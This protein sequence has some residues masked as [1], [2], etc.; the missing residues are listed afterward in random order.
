MILY[1]A[2]LSPYVRKVLFVLNYKKMEFEHKFVLP[3]T[4]TDEYLRISPLGKIPALVDGDLNLPDSSVICHY[5]DEHFPALPIRPSSDDDKAR[6]HWIEEYADTVVAEA[7]SRIFFQRI[8][9][10]VIKNEQSDEAMVDELI[11]IKAPLIQDYLETVVPQEGFLFSSIGLADISITTH[12]IGASYAKYNVDAS[13]WPTLAGY[14]QRVMS[15][16]IVSEIIDKDKQ[17]M[18]K[19][20]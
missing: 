8:I 13:R 18:A 11:N 10:P 7:I 17:A 6:A 9:K 20:T 15:H 1:G 4:R 14:L 19:M 3:A 2:R 5:L 12:F 16:P